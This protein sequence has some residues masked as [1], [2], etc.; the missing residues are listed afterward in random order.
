M[1]K[2]SALLCERQ[3]RRVAVPLKLLS[4]SI[5][6]S[7]STTYA[8]SPAVYPSH[9]Y[10]GGRSARELKMPPFSDA[11][12]S[13][14]E[15]PDVRSS[16]DFAR[17]FSEKNGWRTPTA[18]VGSSAPVSSMHGSSAASDISSFLNPTQR[19]RRI[20]KEVRLEAICRFIAAEAPDVLCLQDCD[21]EAMAAIEAIRMA[22][23]SSSESAAVTTE[24]YRYQFV[25]S[26]EIT[27]TGITCSFIKIRAST[28]ASGGTDA[29][30]EETET[31]GGAPW[32]LDGV[33][34]GM[35]FSTFTVRPASSPIG[36]RSPLWRHGSYVTISNID[37]THVVK[38]LALERPS[39][40]GSAKA[41]PM[42]QKGDTR[43]QG[44][45]QQHPA[46][47]DR[48]A[49]KGAHPAEDDLAANFNY[50]LRGSLPR[51]ATYARPK[52]T[53]TKLPNNSQQIQREAALALL[54]RGG[55]RLY[56]MCDEALEA[57]GASDLSRGVPAVAPD[58]IIGNTHLR[59]GW[60][61]DR[62]T[63]VLPRYVDAWDAAGRSDATWESY[64]F[65]DPKNA[66][67]PSSPAAQTNC[68]Y[69]ADGAVAENGDEHDDGDSA[70]APRGGA[71][72]I[73]SR[74]KGGRYSRCLV[75]DTL[76]PRSAGSLSELIAYDCPRPMVEENCSC[77][78]QFPM[79][80][81]LQ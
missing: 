40:S 54:G 36:L 6:R 42:K 10:F 74:E 39:A 78:D 45:Q 17:I 55:E 53:A 57:A 70:P 13:A 33:H 41:K 8:R 65:Y 4:W 60:T 47:G 76:L 29:K 46:G 68:R 37:L 49:G 38:D 63:N 2:A 64:A 30:G 66:P 3:P 7:E 11:F 73:D 80:V 79:I 75:R 14:A 71:P 69:F 18:G 32:V 25:N 16:A 50:T 35:P 26:V 31:A 52:G 81:T 12:I 59:H 21:D 56:D 9:T 61:H 77:A 51:A 5:D 72:K 43:Q 24:L 27:A 20:A 48:S 1:L 23:P 34:S 58:V 22:P 44:Q 28:A 62:M 67:P 19:T 15:A